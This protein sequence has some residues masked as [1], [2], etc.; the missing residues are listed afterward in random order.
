MLA[1]GLFLFSSSVPRKQ[2][3]FAKQLLTLSEDA[4]RNDPTVGMELGSGL[5]AGGVFASSFGKVAVTTTTNSS[6]SSSST[7]YNIN[8]DNNIDEQN[9]STSTASVEV[10]QLVLQFQINGGNAWA[11]GV[12]Y[13]IRPSSSLGKINGNG[14]NYK[15]N[16]EENEVKLLSL[17]V[18]NMDAVLNGQAFQLPL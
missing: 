12:A 4:L 3:Q 9:Q 6:T 2:Q 14:N 11:Q 13:G 17:E 5:E 1:G 16:S 10:E 15:N 7:A 8:D 18:A